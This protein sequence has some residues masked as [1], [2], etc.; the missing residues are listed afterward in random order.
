M[1]QLPTEKEIF[2]IAC[3]LETE[4]LRSEYLGQVCGEDE[5]LRLRIEVLLRVAREETGLLAALPVNGDTEATAA[6][7]PSEQPGGTIGPYR[8]CERIGEGG[9]GV[10][11]A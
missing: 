8:L 1:P 11:Y 3:A 5:A 2:R 9:F 10:V 7:P 4:E 6:W